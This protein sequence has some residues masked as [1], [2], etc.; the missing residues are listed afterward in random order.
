MDWKILIKNFRHKKLQTI[1]I[2]LIIMLC[3][4]L[5]TS[6]VSI[7]ISLDKP[8]EEFAKECESPSAV[9]F[10]Y[11]SDEQALISLGK[12]F[13]ELPQIARVEYKR[14][15]FISEEFTY[16]GEKLEGFFKLTEVNQNINSKERYLEGNKDVINKLRTNECILPACISNEYNIHT[17]DVIK[18]KLPKETLEYTVRAVFYQP[19]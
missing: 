17:G 11:Y 19:V 18:I 7:L 9:L 2:F 15:H 10:P 5:L 12:Q 8:F 16:N 14:F 1:L 3:S 4:M 6:S 13:A